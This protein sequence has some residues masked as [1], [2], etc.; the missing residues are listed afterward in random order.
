MATSLRRT[1]LSLG[2]VPWG[3]H[4]CV[5]YETKEDLL[6]TL[7]A[8]FKA[9]LE[10][11]E[12]CL[13]VISK[14][15][16]LTKRDAWRALRQAVPNLEQRVTA[17]RMELLS[18]DEWFLQG[19][20]FDLPKAIH[21]FNDKLIQALVRG[22]AG[23]RF[24]VSAAWLQ[25]E[26]WTDFYAF[27]NALDRS[28][29]DQRVIV[30]CSFPQASGAAEVLAAARTHHFTVVK[31]KGA[32]ETIQT[33]DAPTRTHSLTPREV[34]VLRWAARGK[35]AWEIGKVLHIAKRTVDEHV[36]TAVRKLGASNRT[37]AVVIALINRIIEVDT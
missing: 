7:V 35:S 29:A 14:D 32:W 16:P 30:L 20:D 34:E 26:N 2:D 4:S 17:G 31:R 12:F 10:S 6:D 21:H 13:W 8:F 11:D 24:T 28:I 22:Q 37:Q 15:E 25:R 18:H 3:T 27:E 23:M 33:A 19:G 36:Q 5:F 1:G 9:G